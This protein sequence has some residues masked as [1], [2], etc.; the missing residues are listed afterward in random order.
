[1]SGIHNSGRRKSL[2]WLWLS[3]QQRSELL[4]RHLHKG[5]LPNPLRHHPWMQLL[6][7]QRTTVSLL[8]QIWHGEKSNKNGCEDG[9]QELQRYLDVAKSL[10]DRLFVSGQT[11][12]ASIEGGNFKELAVFK[13][14]TWGFS[15]KYQN[16]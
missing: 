6:Q 7:L 14:C 2:W 15:A 8:P 9:S 1:M 16:E 3:K 12:T 5:R 10:F 4:W 13:A 11:C